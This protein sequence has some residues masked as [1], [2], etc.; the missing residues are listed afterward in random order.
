MF[1]FWTLAVGGTIGTIYMAYTLTSPWC[2]VG[3]PIGLILSL[4]GCGFSCSS[5][6]FYKLAI[7]AAEEEPL[8]PEEPMTVTVQ[9]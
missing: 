8:L 3:V 7:R 4:T 1:F 5:D 6:G 9:E 2:Y